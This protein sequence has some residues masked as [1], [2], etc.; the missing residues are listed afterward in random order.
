MVG[1]K[2][3]LV[4]GGFSQ[5]GVTVL[6]SSKPQELFAMMDGIPTNSL[7]AKPYLIISAEADP[8][9]LLIN[10]KD[11]T[12][13]IIIFFIFLQKYRLDSTYGQKDNS[14]FYMQYLVLTKRLSLCQ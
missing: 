1:G 5:S 4:Q 8:V 13:V 9:K 12:N 10:K 14:V 6:V 3:K 11:P 7:S 2:L